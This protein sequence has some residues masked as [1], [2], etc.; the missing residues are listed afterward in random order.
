MYAYYICI[1]DEYIH[2]YVYNT[3]KIYIWVYGS[4]SLQ[5]SCMFGQARDVTEVV[6]SGHGRH[7]T[8]PRLVTHC[9]W[10]VWLLHLGAFKWVSLKMG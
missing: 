1:Y 10:N 2:I 5:I 7:D 3:I 6:N 4:I 8:A 9:S